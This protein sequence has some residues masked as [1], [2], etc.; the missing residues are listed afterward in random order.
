MKSRK[1][2]TILILNGVMLGLVLFFVGEIF[3]ISLGLIIEALCLSYIVFFGGT[4]LYQYVTIS[5]FNKKIQALSYLLLENRDIAGYLA[6]NKA[7]LAKTRKKELRQVIYMNTSAGYSYQG[8]YEKANEILL[9]VD[10]EILDRQNLAILYNNIAH[11]YFMSGEISRGCQIM[12]EQRFLLEVAK[13]MPA[14]RPSVSVT[15]ALWRFAIGDEDGGFGF[16]KEA[17]ECAK[18]PCERQA[19]K[20]IWARELMQRNKKTEAAEILHELDEQET[21]P[22]VESE[23]KRLLRI[24]ERQEQEETKQQETF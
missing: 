17:M 5:C 23:T 10:K 3:H 20:M 1:K 16:L 15:F 12:E 18:L 2:L 6:G 24:L 11:N 4:M 13:S 19:A 14:A 22:S 21:M 7:L 9:D 8:E